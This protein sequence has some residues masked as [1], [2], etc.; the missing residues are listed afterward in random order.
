MTSIFLSA[1]IGDFFALEAFL[2]EHFKKSVTKVY[3]GTKQYENIKPFFISEEYPNLKEHIQVW[4]DFSQFWSFESKAHTINW[5]H[6][7]KHSDLITQGLLDAMDF[8]IHEIFPKFY[9]TWKY[10]GSKVLEH[11]DTS[12]T[13]YLPK[14]YVF[15]SPYSYDKR[16]KLRDFT[17][18]DWDAVIKYLS[19]G[20]VGVVINQGYKWVPEHDSL[21]DMTDKTTL[22][23]AVGILKQANE[24]VGIDSCFSPLATKIL[25]PNNITI[26]SV[27]DHCY[28]YL[29]P[30]F[31]PLK[32]FNFVGRSLKEVLFRRRNIAM[33]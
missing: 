33:F 3:Y 16:I 28:R 30:Y 15:I 31:A 14:N 8:S 4:R 24:Y 18:S 1:G 7:H 29:V 22:N 9:H 21:I 25:K 13:K 19:N 20:K 26:K 6:K 2:P 10:N 17:E 23:Q 27:N 5:L 11:A 12:L 32:Y